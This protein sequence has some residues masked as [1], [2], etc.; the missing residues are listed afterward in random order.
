[1][2]SWATGQLAGRAASGP[3]SATQQRTAGAAE[4][5]D[6]TGA[7][8]DQDEVDETSSLLQS[9]PAADPSSTQQQAKGSGG[10]ETKPAGKRAAGGRAPAW[11]GLHLPELPTP[12]AVMA[13]AAQALPPTLALGAAALLAK[14][15]WNI[16]DWTGDGAEDEAG[17]PPT[18]WCP[19][20]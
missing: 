4:P 1:M 12:G 5:D 3:R 20:L 11:Q 19:W 7:S 17:A 9:E 8:E 13:G 10:S 18:G 14:S 16:M 6:E 15:L 2:H